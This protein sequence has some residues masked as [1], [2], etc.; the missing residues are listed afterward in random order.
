MHPKNSETT[1]HN[2]DSINNTV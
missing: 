1:Q 2:C